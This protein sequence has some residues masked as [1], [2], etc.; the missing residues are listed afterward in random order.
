MP[1]EDA[2]DRIVGWCRQ[3]YKA[4]GIVFVGSWGEPGFGTVVPRLE[5]DLKKFG[6]ANPES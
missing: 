1:V 4:A 2:V 3:V 5:M 6:W